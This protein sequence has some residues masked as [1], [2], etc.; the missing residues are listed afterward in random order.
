VTGVPDDLVARRFEQPVER[1]RQLDDAERRA[2]MATGLGDGRDD[3]LADLGRQLLELPLGEP[4]QLCGPLEFLKDRHAGIG[5]DGWMVGRGTG[6]A[7]AV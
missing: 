4:A 6:R 5:S 7:P 2:E 3:R 1:D